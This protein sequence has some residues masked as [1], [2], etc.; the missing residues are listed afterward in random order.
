M[1]DQI[2]EYLKLVVAGGDRTYIDEYA[3]NFRVALT[4]TYA[5]ELRQGERR[6]NRS[7]G[8]LL[9]RMDDCKT[10]AFDEYRRANFGDPEPAKAKLLECHFDDL[11]DRMI[12][13]TH[14]LTEQLYSVINRI[15]EADHAVSTEI[16]FRKNIWAI[17]GGCNLAAN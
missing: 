2:Q 14:L 12:D 6:A 11:D 16:A 13:C 1:L 9:S 5:M 10:M 3:H 8:G 7:D 15:G 4:S 17:H